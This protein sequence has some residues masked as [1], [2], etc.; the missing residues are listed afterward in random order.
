MKFLNLSLLLLWPILSVAQ[1]EYKWTP[2]TIIK[3]ESAG[4]FVLSENGDRVVFTKRIANTKKDRFVSKLWVAYLGK[5]EAELLQ[6]THGN[7][8]EYSPMLS[9]DGNKVYFQSSRSEKGDQVFVL[10]LRGGEATEL[11]SFEHGISSPK[12]VADRYIFFMAED[13]KNLHEITMKNKEDNVIV[14]EDSTHMNVARMYRYDMESGDILRIT[15]NKYPIMDAEISADGAWIISSHRMSTHFASDGRPFPTY[16]LWNVE[17]GTSELILKDMD[18]PGGFLASKDGKGFY[19]SAEKYIP[20]DHWKY[21][22][23]RELYFFS[24][25]DKSVEAIPMPEGR[26][27]SWGGMMLFED[28]LLFRVGKGVYNPAHIA[29]KGKNGW[30][31]S[32]ISN[33]FERGNLNILATSSQSDRIIYSWSDASTPERY[34]F[35]NISSRRKKYA[36]RAG[37]ELMKMNTML[38]DLP[39]A[40][41]EI[42]TWTGALGESVEG[43]LYYP[44]D[45]EEGSTYPLIVGPHGGPHASDYDAWESSWAYYP[46]VFAERGS[47]FLKPNYHGSSGYGLEFGASINGDGKYYDLPLEDVITGIDYLAERGLVDKNELGVMGWS[48]GAIIATM[49]SVRY[50][51]MFKIVAA[52]AGDVNWT[53]DYGTCRFGVAFDQSYLGGAPWDDVDGKPYNESYILQ[54]PLFEIEKVKAPT[55]IFHGS[56]DRAVPRDQGWEYYRGLQ[57]VGQ[58]PVRFLWFPGQPHGLRKIT[59]Q[60]R[61]V[62]EEITWFEKYFFGTFE[63]GN[64]AFKEKSPLAYL[65]YK[66]QFHA[67]ELVGLEENGL[68]LPPTAA[69][70]KG[71]IAIGVFEVTQAQW[72]AF[73]GSTDQLGFPNHPALGISAEEA[74]AYIQWLNEKTGKTYRLPN[75]EELKNWRKKVADKGS[76]NTIRHWAG[77]EIQVDDFQKLMEKMP[78]DLSA[79]VWPVGQAKPVNIS[80][81]K[82][83]DLGGNAGE[84]AV[85]EAGNLVKAFPSAATLADENLRNWWIPE[86]LMG[87]RVV[88]ELN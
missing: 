49:L 84:W 54:S 67:Q 21:I 41:T 1:I 88:L 3:Q 61:K 9:K 52:G 4:S 87:L 32:P 77:Y 55:I 56:E 36:V 86:E 12:M 33:E 70:K 34:F 7:D 50:P 38:E 17:E 45:Y 30:E 22:G 31:S 15:D 2:D 40:R 5:D 68:L 62:E 51:D 76:E 13:G 14:V 10:D 71:D 42:I 28:G 59:H 37:G 81:A 66:Q 74:K 16:R 46:N 85:D 69:T 64:S 65:H 23:V 83:F 48:N 20:E 8:S 6:L 27:L 35:G 24:I 25:N 75:A 60:T 26:E 79:M 80:G 11:F 82:V 29:I 57:Q 53:S 18:S 44:H 43:I 73:T 39:K 78:E 19:F 58:A 47:F 72:N 63:E